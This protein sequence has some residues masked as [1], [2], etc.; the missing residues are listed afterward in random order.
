MVSNRAVTFRRTLALV[1]ALLLYSPQSSAAATQAADFGFRFEFGSCLVERLDTFTGTF[2]QG[3]PGPSPRI[4]TTHIVLTDTQMSA[5]YRAVENVRFF[6]Y[7][8]HFIGVRPDVEVITTI[9]STTYRFEVTNAGVVHT[10]SWN[11][12][13]KPAT[14][15]ADRLRAFFSM[16]VALIHDHPEFKRLP[17][18]NMGCM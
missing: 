12:S 8:T 10:V 6:D 11:D 9:P 18:V 5:I 3:V 2:T 15:E 13:S 16:V 7:P 1:A 14:P 4:A 17:R